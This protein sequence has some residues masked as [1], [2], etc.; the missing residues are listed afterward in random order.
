ML[1]PIYETKQC[2]NYYNL[3]EPSDCFI[4]VTNISIFF[5][6]NWAQTLTLVMLM[7]KIRN[8]KDELNLKKELYLV[9]G[10]WL[11]FSLLYFSALQV[12]MSTIGYRQ[13]EE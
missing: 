8:V 6:V 1:V 7:W 11:V 3:R 12:D 10:I 5:I 4:I 13:A 2:F 9:I